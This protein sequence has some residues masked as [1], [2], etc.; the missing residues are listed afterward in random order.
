[1]ST[2]K[3]LQIAPTYYRAN[4]FEA[5]FTPKV[6][7]QLIDVLHKPTVRAE[8][9]KFVLLVECSTSIVPIYTETRAEAEY[10]IRKLRKVLRLAFADADYRFRIEDK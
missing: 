7:A 2:A 4:K 1:M 8:A 6:F 5:T 3:K 9:A 10:C